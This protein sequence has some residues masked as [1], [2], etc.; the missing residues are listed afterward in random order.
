M[1]EVLSNKEVDDL[2]KDLECRDITEES[3]SQ[4]SF[5]EAGER[6]I[7]AIKKMDLMWQKMI[8]DAK[9]GHSE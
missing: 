9:W 4:K 8:L 6:L 7:Y 5:E 1:S 2:L 3:P